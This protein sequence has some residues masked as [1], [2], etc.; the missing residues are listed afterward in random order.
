M[1]KFIHIIRT[2][3]GDFPDKDALRKVVR[4]HPDWVPIRDVNQKVVNPSN[5]QC[6]DYLSTHDF[7]YLNNTLAVSSAAIKDH[8][9]MTMINDVELDTA[10][11]ELDTAPQSKTLRDIA[12]DCL[13]D[14]TPFLANDKTK[15]IVDKVLDA[16]QNAQIDAHNEALANIPAP[17]A[18]PGSVTPLRQPK[19]VHLSNVG[20]TFNLRSARAKEVTCTVFD[21]PNAPKADRFYEFPADLTPEIV[22]VIERGLQGVWLGGPPSTSKSSLLTQI[23]AATKRPLAV[24]EGSASLDMAEL[25]GG[26]GLKDGQTQF[27][28]GL[29]TKAIQTAQTIIVIDECHKIPQMAI[30]ALQ[31]CLASR[32]VHIPATGQIIPFAKG[33]TVHCTANDMGYSDETGNHFG[34]EMDTAFMDRFDMVL[35]SS[36]MPK[37]AEARALSGHLRVKPDQVMPFVEMANLSRKAMADGKTHQAITFRALKAWV[38]AL[39]GGMPEKL[40]FESCIVNKMKPAFG[41]TQRQLYK[42]DFAGKASGAIAALRGITIP[43]IAPTPVSASPSVTGARFPN[44]IETLI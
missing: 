11:L 36:Y 6:I 19:V 32:E 30:S 34:N 17:N 2:P 7:S 1:S 39:L 35:A 31:T 41:E 12:E 18:A 25:F 10:A 37:E 27:K 33:V 14:I 40:A 20:K 29:F 42:A 13:S 43:A 16:I 44:D 24:I 5:K 23:A 28:E 8:E 26:I 9:A 15:A 3:I 38:Q 22:A 4:A 21:Y